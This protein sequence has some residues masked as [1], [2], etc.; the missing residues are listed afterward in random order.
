MTHALKSPVKR[1]TS[2][3]ARIRPADKDRSIQ[4][5]VTAYSA[6]LHLKGTQESVTVP[7]VAIY[8]LGLK[9]RARQAAAEKLN[10]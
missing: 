7:W 1:E 4:V 9:L 6:I 8:D 3:T 10:G 2:A 5:E